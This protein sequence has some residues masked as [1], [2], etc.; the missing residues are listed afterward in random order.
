MDGAAFSSVTDFVSPAIHL[1]DKPRCIVYL[2]VILDLFDFFVDVCRAL[3]QK[4]IITKWKLLIFLFSALKVLLVK[5]N[6]FKKEKY[7]SNRS[8]VIRHFIL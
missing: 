3:F 6:I 2:K 7:G 1:I 4:I 8:K 5:K